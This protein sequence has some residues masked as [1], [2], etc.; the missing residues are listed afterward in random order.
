MF[1]LNARVA[2]AGGRAAA[3]LIKSSRGGRRAPIKV[4]APSTRIHRARQTAS[5][6][7]QCSS[8]GANAETARDYGVAYVPNG[9]KR[10]AITEALV[11]GDLR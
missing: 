2:R 4:Q 10:T 9:E 5:A 11:M 3:K 6:Q 8:C 7:L 1:G